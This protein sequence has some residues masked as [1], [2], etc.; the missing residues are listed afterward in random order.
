MLS[1]SSPIS[2]LSCF[3]HKI[4]KWWTVLM[5]FFYKKW[6]F[7]IK[8]FTFRC[9]LCNVCG[10]FKTLKDLKN[11]MVYTRPTILAA[12]PLK[13]GKNIQ[14]S[15]LHNPETK[16]CSIYVRS[17]NAIKW[18]CVLT[19]AL[20]LRPD[21]YEPNE[22]CLTTLHNDELNRCKVQKHNSICSEVQ[23]L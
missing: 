13:K 10:S 12:L 2:L 11:E 9:K 15:L 22:R 23:W 17:V 1:I 7:K 21:V 18:Y 16:E 8:G 3:L 19:F 5:F 14:L 6:Y 20:S 4:V